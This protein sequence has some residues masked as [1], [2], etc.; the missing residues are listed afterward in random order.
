[1]QQVPFFIRTV[2]PDNLLIDL[3]VAELCARGFPENPSERVVL[4]G[5]WDSIY[6]R[7]FEHAL[8]GQPTGGCKGKYIKVEFYPYLRG[9]DGAGLDGA[10]KQVRLVRAGDKPASERKDSQIEWPEGRDQRDY[11]RRIVKEISD[12]AT[13][14]SFETEV[15]AVGMIGRDVH[16]KLVLAQALRAAF[17]DRV[18][19][20]T[21]LDA[22]LLHPD[23][24]GYTRNIIVAS[25]LPLTLR[26]D[27]QGGIPPFRDSYQTATFLGARYAAADDGK[28]D[29][30]LGAIKAELAKPRLFEIGLRDK[31][32][33]GTKV[34]RKPE[35]ERRVTYAVLVAVVLLGLGGLVTF[36]RFVPAMSTARLW[37][38]RNKPAEAHFDTASKVVSGLEA[39]AFGFAVGIVIELCAPGSTGYNGALLLGMTT[40]AFFW[41]FLY[42]GIRG[43]S[44]SKT[45]GGPSAMSRWLRFGLRVAFFVWLAWSL[46]EM[47]QAPRLKIYANLSLP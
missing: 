11:V 33:L 44:A 39:V 13:A 12:P 20:T 46:V 24:T 31:V 47:W 8:H 18:L 2:A 42:P 19:F 36:T 17:P 41:A 32:E 15:K 28:R 35:D 23:V 4:F 22:R 14:H 7:T 37:L 26:K 5:E 27:L 45:G 30:R 40:A 1:M 3:L 25:S 29:E 16:D 6:S 9:L 10:S 38:F 43:L 34:S 21:D